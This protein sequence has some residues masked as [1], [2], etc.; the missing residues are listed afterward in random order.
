MPPCID[1][2]DSQEIASKILKG[3]EGIKTTFTKEVIRM[4]AG[5]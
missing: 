2:G 3:L 5:E 4:K 1:G